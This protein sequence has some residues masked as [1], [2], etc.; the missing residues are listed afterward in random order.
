LIDNEEQTY[1]PNFLIPLGVYAYGI[2]YVLIGISHFTH[3]SLFVPIVPKIIGFPEFWVYLSGVFEITLG[4]GLFLQKTR[5]VSSVLTIAMLFV[6]YTANINMWVNDIEFNGVKMT[7]NGHLFRASIQIL[8]IYI[9]YW[10][11]RLSSTG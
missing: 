5:Y 8:L 1:I 7:T 6:L 10:I 3:P 11:S 2:S 9:A 4:L